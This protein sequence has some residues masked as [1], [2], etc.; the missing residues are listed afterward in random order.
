LTSNLFVGINYIKKVENLPFKLA[1]MRKV[2]TKKQIVK[3]KN[4][5]NWIT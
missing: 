4:C 3:V 1:F 2:D 5:R